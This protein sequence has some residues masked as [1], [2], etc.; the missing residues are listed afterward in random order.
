VLE[1]LSN[2]RKDSK[3]RKFTQ[4]V[5]LI[6]NLKQID[7]KKPE[8]KVD[9]FLQLP[10]PRLKKLKICALVDEELAIEAKKHCEYVILKE[11]FK[12]MTKNKPKL[13]KI[14]NE[15][16]F[17]I[18]QPH[19]MPEVATAFGKILGPKG[20]MPNPKAGC[21]IPPKADLKII[22]N[23]LKNT[24]KIATKN[25]TI[26]K[27][28]IGDEGMTD[29][30]LSQNIQQVFNSVLAKLPQHENNIKSVLVKLTMGSPVVIGGAK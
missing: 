17:F 25:D 8:E 27:C 29:E 24:V 1:A 20:K 30:Q 19:L 23:K 10:N 7:I 3:K 11:E 28:A 4:T 22:V 14:T 15:C 13:R 12:I 2:I 5:D 9:L 16:G 26:I 18:T 21:I 6:L